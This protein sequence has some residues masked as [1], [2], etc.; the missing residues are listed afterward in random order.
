MEDFPYY[1]R[2]T[3]VKTP[4]ESLRK[5]L[6]ILDILSRFGGTMGAP[7]SLISGKMGLLQNTTHNLLKTLCL[8]GYARNVG[9]GRYVLGTGPFDLVKES[10][11]ARDLHPMLTQTI[12]RLSVELGEAVVL[13]VL[14]DGRRRVIGRATGQGAVQV[15]ARSVDNEEQP[16]WTTV[17]GRI[18]AA[19]CTEEE[20]A[21]LVGNE[22]FPRD[23]WDG[24]TEMGSLSLALDLIRR[25]GLAEQ[26]QANEVAS[27]AVPILDHTNT[28]TGALGLHCPAYRYNPSRQQEFIAGLRAG[29]ARLAEALRM[30][31]RTMADSHEGFN[32]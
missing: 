25:N 30:V 16:L 26:V 29:S 20:L 19:Y 4:V 10:L 14:R 13:A 7:L 23:A 12:E 3:L 22:G 31:C 11:L 2:M 27:I 15:D 8:C 24:I 28:L 9:N 21:R 6:A 1:G 17:T 32:N 5:G 18:L